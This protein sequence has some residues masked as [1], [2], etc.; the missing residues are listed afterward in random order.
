VLDLRL[1]GE[2]ADGREAELRAALELERGAV[3]EAER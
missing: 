3:N 1:D 2:I